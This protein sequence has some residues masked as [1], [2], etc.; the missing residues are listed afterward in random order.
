[1]ASATK[2][3]AAFASREERIVAYADRRAGQR[4]ES[5]DARFAS[6]RRRYPRVGVEVARRIWDDADLRPSGREPIGSRPTS[7]VPPAW[8]RPTSADWPG[9]GAALRAARDGRR[10]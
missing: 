2:R 4:L 8:H 6:W 1:M 5:M 7:A 10:T 3:W 9:P